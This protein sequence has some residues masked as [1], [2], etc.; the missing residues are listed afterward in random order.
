MYGPE[1][2]ALWK[3][4]LPESAGAFA[5]IEN[6]DIKNAAK[7]TRSAAISIQSRVRYLAAGR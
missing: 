5:N 2:R 3:M 4:P 6:A 1:I 7:R